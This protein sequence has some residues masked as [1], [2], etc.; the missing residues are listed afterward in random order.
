VPA[1]EDLAPGQHAEAV[2]DHWWWRPGWGTGR[3]SYAWH[4]TFDGAAE[5]HAVAE[6]YRQ[7]L[8][9]L[10][11]TLIPDRWLHLTMQGVGFTDEV[12][13][14]DRDAIAAAVLSRLTRIQP[15]TVYL[16]PAV[17]GDEAVALPARPDGRV[18]AVRIAVRDG[19]ADVWGR[20]RVPEDGDRYRPHASVA[21]MDADGPV[22]PYVHAISDVR[23]LPASVEVRTVSLIRLHRDRRM[24]EWDTV[25]V[26]EL[27]GS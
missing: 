16:G 22:A 12:S 17:V 26:C 15:F 1:L 23:V 6:R 19:I 10:P 2:R 5:L 9:G 3:S 21:Y 7:S 25:A 11:V 14:A 20:D 8:A 27:A 4:I 18:R 24:Y 13:E